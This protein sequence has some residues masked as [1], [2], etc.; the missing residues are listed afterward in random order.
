MTEPPNPIA[1]TERRLLGVP[2]VLGHLPDPMRALG[3]DDYLLIEN[4]DTARVYADLDERREPIT[5]EACDHVARQLGRQLPSPTWWTDL[6]CEL[7]MSR[8]TVVD[9]HV[10]QMVSIVTD[11]ANRRRIERDSTEIAAAARNECPVNDL[12]DRVERAAMRA[13]AAIAATP[14]IEIPQRGCDEAPEMW[15]KPLPPA[16]PTPYAALDNLLGGGLRGPIVANAPSGVGKT[17]LAIGTGCGIARTHTVVYMSTELSPRQICAR[18]AAQM[19]NQPWRPIFEGGPEMGGV[20]A[21]ALAGLDFRAMDLGPQTDIVGTLS[22]VADRL[23]KPPLLILDYLQGAARSAPAESD[24]RQIIDAASEMIMR[25][26]C[27]S[28]MPAI[29]VS[30]VG[31]ASYSVAERTPA[32]LVGT[33]KESGTIEYDAA[34]VLYLETEPCPLGGSS[35]ARLHVA[36]SRFGATGTVGLRF[37]GASGRFTEDQ[38]ASLAPDQRAVFDAVEAGATTYDDLRAAVAMNKQ[39]TLQIVKALT[40]RRLIDTNPLR[41]L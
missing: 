23:G 25:W 11:H 38:L 27:E 34:A 15:A 7:A 19:L 12:V 30:A 20:V 37:H 18:A 14:G 13:R 3:A 16:I 36:K 29:V 33:A 39:K 5:P 35:N 22:R 41:V 31:R 32:E 9:S 26:T 21:D 10:V 40:A 4:Q 6:A 8:E 2:L 1:T 24:R 28:G 17:S